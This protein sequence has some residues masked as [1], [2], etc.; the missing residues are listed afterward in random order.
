MGGGFFP[1]WN[2]DFFSIFEFFTYSIR[3]ERFQIFGVGDH[4]RDLDTFN[5]ISRP[6]QALKVIGVG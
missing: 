5:F 4:I 1:P 3:G 6:G 2:I